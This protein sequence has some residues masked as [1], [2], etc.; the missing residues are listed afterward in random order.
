MENDLQLA[1]QVARREWRAAV[2]L[3]CARYLAPLGMDFRACGAQ[4]AR[5]KQAFPGRAMGGVAWRKLLLLVQHA[6]G[7]MLDASQ[8]SA[9]VK[10]FQKVA[11]AQQLSVKEPVV[12]SPVVEFFISENLPEQRKGELL[13]LTRENMVG[14]P[15][16]ESLDVELFQPNMNFVLVLDRPGGPVLGFTAVLFENARAC[17]VFELQVASH[18]RAR[19]IGTLLLQ[20]IVSKCH[21]RRTPRITLVVHA[22]NARARK[23]YERA[24]FIEDDTCPAF[25]RQLSALPHRTICKVV[26]PQR[27]DRVCEVPG[28]GRAYRTK[29]GIETHMAVAHGAPWPHPCAMCGAGATTIALLNEHVAGAHGDQLSR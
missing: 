9:M 14:L 21:A 23:F 17:F 27:H 16:G 25:M 11:A 7:A 8:L 22:S 29:L 19:G 10:A 20:Q 24:G 2:H 28:C 18:A 4:L 1:R 26:L 13:C 3:I 12:A 15:R 5:L 6:T